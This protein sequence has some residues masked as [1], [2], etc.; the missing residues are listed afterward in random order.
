MIH[1]EDLA[2]GLVLLIRICHF[3]FSLTLKCNGAGEVHWAKTD[4]DDF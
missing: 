4:I 2:F 3:Q 1:H